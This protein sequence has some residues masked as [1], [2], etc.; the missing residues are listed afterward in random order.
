MDL[1][2]LLRRRAKLVHEARQI[3]DD[4]EAEDR[5]LTA[6]EEERYDKLMDDAGDLKERIDRIR[7][8]REL[9]DEVEGTEGRQAGG[10][11][12][13]E[14]GET[15][16]DPRATEEYRDAYSRY[17][18]EGER[19]ISH[20]EFR[21]LQAD[22]DELGGYM[23]MPTQQAGDLV[24][25]VDDRMYIRQ[26]GRGFMVDGASSLG[27]VSLDADPEDA[28]W[29]SEIADASEDSQMDFGAR[30]LHPQELKKELKISRKLIRRVPNADELIRDRLAYKFAVPREKG[31]LT[32]DGSGQPLG[33]FTASDQGVSTSRDVSTDNTTTEV[34]FDNLI[35]VKYTLKPQYWDN[36]R[37]MFHR[38]VLREV[39]KLKNGNGQYIWRES[40]R[41]GEPDRLLNI[42]VFMSEF[43]PNT[44]TS[45]QYVGVLGDFSHYW[46]ADDMNVMIQALF[47]LYA[48]SSQVGYI[49]E[50]AGDGMPVLEEAF[51]RVKLG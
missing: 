14:G 26:W 37:W 5:G 12:Q 46:Y 27:V 6:E 50:W 42:P 35:T 1:K 47:E 36:A 21:A 2:K 9:E 40:T 41:A 45:G 39:A 3:L 43:A 34:T 30:E 23:V 49:G 51:V 38:D 15:R 29:T 22:D 33:V 16:N 25:A 8:Q 31:Y 10:H 17:V 28:E 19:A 13:P 7:A 44:M 48:K 18:T 24:Q 4:A 32:G 20:E 11:E